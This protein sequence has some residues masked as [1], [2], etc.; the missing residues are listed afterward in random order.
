MTTTAPRAEAPRAHGTVPAGGL[1]WAVHEGFVAYVSRLADGRVDVDGGAVR[2]P[3]GSI[4]FP[5]APDGPAL[6]GTGAVRF[7]GHHGLLA[8]TLANPAVLGTGGS[9]V[10][11]IDDPFTPGERLAFAR[12]GA[13]AS[14][15][16]ACY[17][18]PTLTEEGADLFLGNYREG[19][20]LAPLRIQAH[21]TTT[22]QDARDD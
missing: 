5:L 13:P 10:L 3:D 1:L 6:H 12:L 14:G 22:D 11:A 17:P 8:V 18:A 7:T 2:Q 4:L 9:A 15:Q 20:P 21:S 19:T 16:A